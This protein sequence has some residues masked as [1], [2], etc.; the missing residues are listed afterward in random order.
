MIAIL[1][2]RRAPAITN[3][4]PEWNGFIKSRLS[5]LT[6]AAASHGRSAASRS[7]YHPGNRLGNQRHRITESANL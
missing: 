3:D 4:S 6:P 5:R 7:V 2:R 1:P